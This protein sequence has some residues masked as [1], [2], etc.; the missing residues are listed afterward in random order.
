MSKKM[1]TFLALGLGLG[2]SGSLLAA[3]QKATIKVYGMSCQMCANGVAA[4]V[5]NLTKI[6]CM[7]SHFGFAWLYLGSFT[8][9]LASNSRVKAQAHTPLSYPSL[10]EKELDGALV[11]LAINQKGN[12]P[13]FG[14]FP[15]TQY[16][17]WYAARLCWPAALLRSEDATDQAL[18]T[19]DKHR[20]A[21]R[22]TR[23]TVARGSPNSSSR[24]ALVSNA[25]PST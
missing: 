16:S 5:K 24:R 15:G 25:S 20:A 9:R 11:G 1:K 14:R 23:A 19:F 22:P 21:K 4:S 2:L 7:G 18:Q 13:I 6:V 12:E 8:S 17:F 3:E 10:R